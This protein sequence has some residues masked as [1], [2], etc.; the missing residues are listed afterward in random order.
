MTLATRLRSSTATIGKAE[1]WRSAK[2]GLLGHLAASQAV[3]AALAWVHAE[4][5]L[6]AAVAMGAEAALEGVLEDEE[7]TEAGMAALQH[8]HSTTA[9][10]LLPPHLIPLPITPLLVGKEVRLST[11]AM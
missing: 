6:Q 4:V 7:H 1:C 9:L 8:R 2:I 11:S 3:V 10:L 5:A